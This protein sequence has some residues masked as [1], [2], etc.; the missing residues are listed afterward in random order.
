[1]IITR[2][3]PGRRLAVNSRHVQPQ[4][5]GNDRIPATR[6]LA[7]SRHGEY[8]GSDGVLQRHGLVFLPSRHIPFNPFIRIKR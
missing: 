3:L 7:Q 8:Q 2:A 5:N 6:D 1:M 4:Y